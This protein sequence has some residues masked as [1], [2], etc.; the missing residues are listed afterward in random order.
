ML[1]RAPLQAVVITH[2]RR[3]Q[4]LAPEGDPK[5]FEVSWEVGDRPNL[6]SSATARAIA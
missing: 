6:F 4:S 1:T 2:A 3:E 5:H